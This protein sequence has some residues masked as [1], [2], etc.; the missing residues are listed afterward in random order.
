MENSNDIHPGRLLALSSSYWHACALHA[1]VKLEVFTQLA[2]RQLSAAEVA[3]ELDASVRGMELLLNALV[4]MGLLSKNEGR[5]TD[6]SESAILLNRASPRYVGFI[7]MHH[8]HLVDGWAQ[9]DD[10]VRSGRP[11]ARRSHGEERERESFQ[12]GMYNLA[13]AIAPEI[14]GIVDLRG[15]HRLLDLGGGPGTH[16]VHF[17]LANRQLEATVF[18]R[19]TTEPFARLTAE[20]FEVT[21]RVGFVAGDFLRDPLPAGHD[22]AWLS[23]IL[24][25]NSPED[26]VALIKKT[27]ASLGSGGLLFVH[28]FFLDDSMAGPLFPALFALNMLIGNDGRSYS[29]MEIREMMTAAGVRDIVRLPFRGPNDSGILQGEVG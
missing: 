13:M 19:S 25:S 15:R 20:R 22:V 4:A 27:A 29:E 23:Q 8:H 16:A 9:L 28:E 17:C 11:V 7:I 5:F 21:D 10:A 26:C 3:T 18:D 1:G 2:D 12:M 14:A 6:T 24:H